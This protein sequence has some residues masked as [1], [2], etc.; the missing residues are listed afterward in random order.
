MCSSSLPPPNDC[1]ELLD[2][3]R[4]KFVLPGLV[5]FLVEIGFLLVEVLPVSSYTL[6]RPFEESP[7]K[8]GGWGD[9][10]RISMQLS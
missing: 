8:S 3:Q 4:S 9:I 10:D 2:S 1:Q 5:D 6:L 7:G